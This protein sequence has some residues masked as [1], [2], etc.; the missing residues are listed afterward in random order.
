VNDRVVGR[1][2]AAGVGRMATR[3]KDSQEMRKAIIQVCQQFR[4]VLDR[5]DKAS[6]PVP[7]LD[8]PHGSCDPASQV[9]GRLLRERLRIEVSHVR[10]QESIHERGSHAWLEY[11]GLIIDVTADQFESKPSILVTKSRRWHR[12]FGSPAYAK[13]S[14]DD[15]WFAQYCAPVL[16]LFQR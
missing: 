2:D 15:E 13:L 9:L 7:F 10:A 1:A 6:L 3:K 12:K 5:A 14:D 16:R 11:Q 8:F 4:E